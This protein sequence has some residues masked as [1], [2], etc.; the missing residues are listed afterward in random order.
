[1]GLLGGDNDSD[2][3][4]FAA[5]RASSAVLGD[6]WRA[7]TEHELDPAPLPPRRRRLLLVAC[8]CILGNEICERMAFYAV[9]TNMVSRCCPRLPLRGFWLWGSEGSATTHTNH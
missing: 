2:D 8:L 7:K 9:S 3:D 4:A 1:M 6:Q 5:R